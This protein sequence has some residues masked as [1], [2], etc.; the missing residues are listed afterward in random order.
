M[1]AGGAL[2]KPGVALGLVAGD[3]AGHAL[4]GDAHLLG[5]MRAG[6]ALDQDTLDDQ[7][8]AMHGQAGI[9][10]KHQDLRFVV[11]AR[12][13]PHLNRRSSHDQQPQAACHDPTVTNVLAEYS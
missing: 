6:P 4:A 8:P 9:T 7:A 5:H 11:R 10:V 2:R 13:K 1:W 3:P 12:G